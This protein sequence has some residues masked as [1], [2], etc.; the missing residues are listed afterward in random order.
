MRI[1]VFL[2]QSPWGDIDE[3][4]MGK[5]L[6]G[7][8]TA[9]VQLAVNWAS[10]G[11]DVFA[12]VPRSNTRIS[13][14][15]KWIPMEQVISIAPVLDLDMFVS[16]ENAEVLAQLEGAKVGVR[17]IEMQVAHLQSSVPLES[18]TDYIAVL[19]EWAGDFLHE[20]H[21]NFPRE[22][23]VV[24]PNGVDLDRFTEKR[25]MIA[26]DEPPTFIYSSSPDR[27]LHHLLNM[28]PD[29]RYALA[30]YS[31]QTPVLHVCYGVENFV[32]QKWTHGPAAIRALEIE[33]GINQEGVIYH[34]KVG[35]DELAT[36]MINSDALL[37]P[38]DTMSHTET[39]CITIVEALAAGTDVVTTN[40]DCLGSEF[41]H[42]TNQSPLPLSYGDFIDRVVSVMVGDFIVD[43]DDRAE[44]VY[45]RD[46]E[47]ISGQW[48]KWLDR[49]LNPGD[50]IL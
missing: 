48:T 1:G 47:Y 37:Y 27:G 12:F 9:L 25:T 14:G 3:E 30:D 2:H 4:A 43:E 40:C 17:V 49:L 34:G 35:Q 20:Q 7:R 24:F 16:W 36:L 46:W 38:C 5:G 29:I 42:I 44:F 39:G 11:H 23:I 15:V 18:C 6:G 26:D 31:D 19:S 32:G 22:N 28:W 50:L 41:G 8:E 45:Y 10:Q 21:P 13:A 33:E